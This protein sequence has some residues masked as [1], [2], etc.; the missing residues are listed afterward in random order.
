MGDDQGRVIRVNRRGFLN[1]LTLAGGGALLAACGAAPASPTTA[2][3]AMTGSTQV[4]H[5]SQSPG[6]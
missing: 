1:G 3:A 2:P 5:C 6:T 4:G